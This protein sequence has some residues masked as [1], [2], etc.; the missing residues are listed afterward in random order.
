MTKIA[1]NGAAGRMGNRILA[2]AAQSP[3]F[4]IAGA[5]EH[6]ASGLRGKEIDL[7]GGKKMKLTGMSADS[8]KG[9]GV[10]IDFSGPTG[11]PSALVRA[12][13]AG[14]GLVI[15]TTGLDEPTQKAIRAVSR[16]I[17]IVFSANMS[18]GVNLVA[19]LVALAASRLGPEFKISI[20]EAHH[21]H[22]KDSPSGTA[23]MLAGAAALAKGWNSEKAKKEIEIRSIR[24]GEIVGDHTV[25][26]TGPAETIE[27]GHH[28]GSRD[29]FA[30]GALS[31][32]RFLSKKSRGFFTMA[33]VL[34]GRPGA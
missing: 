32:A 31:A 24:E 8:L 15:G 7:G 12:Q 34:G 20:N 25:L 26:F 28:A 9:K 21:I 13:K 11:T 2:L 27:V 5:F 17:P 3:D 33:D 1:V 22:K 16:K 10:L 19:E 29:T 14:W 23:L 6:E 30:R 18:V 4:E